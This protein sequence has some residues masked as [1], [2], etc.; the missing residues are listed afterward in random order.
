MAVRAGRA[1]ATSASG[2]VKPGFSE[3]TNF[4]VVS[5]NP[6]DQVTTAVS[7]GAIDNDL[8]DQQR[9]RNEDSDGSR[10]LV[11]RDVEGTGSVAVSSHRPPAS[12]AVGSLHE[13]SRR[14]GAFLL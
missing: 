12:S 1:C 13:M 4:L 5:R 3:R 14:L 10:R 2:A 7:V 6:T 11:R 8:C 9:L